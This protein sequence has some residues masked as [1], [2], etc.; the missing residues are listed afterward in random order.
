MS[1]FPI[2]PAFA[3]LRCLL[4]AILAIASWPAW[5]ADAEL[6][7]NFETWSNRLASSEAGRLD[8]LVAGLAG[9]RLLLFAP[10]P[11]DAG[12]RRFALSRRATLL[13]ELDRRGVSP[14]LVEVKVGGAS[15]G[16]FTLRMVSSD[17]IRTPLE[18]GGPAIPPLPATVASAATAPTTPVQPPAEPI[19]ITPL[20]PPPGPAAGTGGNS[21]VALTPASSVAAGGSPE[22]PA[23]TAAVSTQEEHW[24]AGSG[25]SLRAV[26]QDWALQA[27]WTLVWR[28]DREYPLE[29]SAQFSGTFTKAASELLEG[30][31][32]AAPAPLGHFFKGNQVLLVDSG[33][34]R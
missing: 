5:A 15:A 32:G 33:E 7:V 26:L 17:P 31:S 21:T 1:L 8:D 24:R 16:T 2:R 23:P 28:S 18:I 12:A 34:G 19:A 3:A 30:F 20:A 14:D 4:S 22:F 27:G 10:K 11:E 6:Q 13:A 9:R 25:Q 29:A